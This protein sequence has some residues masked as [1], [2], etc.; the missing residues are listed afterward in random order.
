MVKRYPKVKEVDS[1]SDFDLAIEA[2]VSLR[3]C[4]TLVDLANKRIDKAYVKFTREIDT[5]TLK[6]F[7]EKLAKVEV[8]EFVDTKPDKSVVDVA[9]GVE[10]YISTGDIDLEPIVNKLTKQKE[11]LIKEINKLNGMLNNEKFVA[12]APKEVIEQ[13]QKALKEAQEKLEKVEGELSS[14]V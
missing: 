3:R 12:N 8:V 2:I 13:N 10:S 5:K 14:L 1:S 11:K 9:N 7:I 6:P 4:K